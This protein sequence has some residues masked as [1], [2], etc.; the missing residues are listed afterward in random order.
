MPAARPS[1]SGATTTGATPPAATATFTF[2]GTRIA[3]LSVKDTGNGYAAVSIDGG[4][5]QTV[6]LHGPIRVGE[7]VQYRS[8]RLGYGAHTLRVRV[9]GQHN[10][11]SQGSFVSIDRAEV[12][13]D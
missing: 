3:L 8:P 5:E 10:G 7:A 2:T 11:Q 1:A 9:T 13:V 6:D 12:Y 4:A